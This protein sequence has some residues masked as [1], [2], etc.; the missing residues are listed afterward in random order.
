VKAALTLGA[1]A[2]A[3]ALLG[4]QFYRAGTWPLLSL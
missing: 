4:A 3:L 2:A 1:P